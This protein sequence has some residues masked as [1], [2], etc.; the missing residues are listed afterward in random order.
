MDSVNSSKGSVGGSGLKSSE[1]DVE[2]MS[3]RNPSSDR[4]KEVGCKSNASKSQSVTCIPTEDEYSQYFPKSRR[5][6]LRL[7]GN[8][9]DDKIFRGRLS[10]NKIR[11][12]LA[13]T[14][15]GGTSRTGSLNDTLSDP[16][17]LAAGS[18]DR[19]HSHNFHPFTMTGHLRNYDS[20]RSQSTSRGSCPS[21][22][23]VFE[24]ASTVGTSNRRG[25]SSRL[26][27]SSPSFHLSMPSCSKRILPRL[28]SAAATGSGPFNSSSGTRLGSRPT[29]KKKC[30]RKYRAYST[31]T[32]SRDMIEDLL[33]LPIVVPD[34]EDVTDDSDINNDSE[35]DGGAMGSRKEIRPDALAEIEVN[36]SSF[37]SPP[38]FNKFLNPTSFIKSNDGNKSLLK[39][40]MLT[41]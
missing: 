18:K 41:I 21:V 26:P 2:A 12:S 37:F 36:F 17:S 11:S 22:D 28:T 33:R 3:C 6:P 7:L 15:S 39:L 4:F 34:D 23:D 32:S 1:T 5:S 24:G 13:D 19:V 10:S 14:S 38:F 16:D 27:P 9:V 40:M 20:R 8:F 30:C 31:P 35:E 29:E 25:S